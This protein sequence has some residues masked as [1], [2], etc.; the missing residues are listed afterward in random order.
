MRACRSSCHHPTR[1]CFQWRRNLANKAPHLVLLRSAAA[2]LPKR[3]VNVARTAV[4]A[5]P[6]VARSSYAPILRFPPKRIDL[7]C[8]G[9]VFFRHARKDTDWRQ[10][11]TYN[12]V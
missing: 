12:P 1:D 6:I 8:R 3:V 10:G 5:V 4:N 9:G 2:S 11:A 7:F